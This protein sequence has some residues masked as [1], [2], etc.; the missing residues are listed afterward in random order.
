MWRVEL[1]ILSKPKRTAAATRRARRGSDKVPTFV[2]LIGAQEHLNV[3][4]LIDFQKKDQQSVEN[5]YKRK[6]L[7]KRKVLTYADYVGSNEADIEDMFS[8]D[9]YLKLVNGAFGSSVGLT[10]LA[11]GH[12]RI[13]HRLEEYLESNPLPNNAIF[14]HYRPARYFSD[15]IG[16]LADDL[17]DQ[18]LDRFEQAFVA[19]NAL[20]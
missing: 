7:N 18:E 16:S 6:L 4:V 14:N 17:S 15:N 1:R 9:F 8:P 20:L 11:G 10:D 2:A 12:P 13:L 19:L 5:L 3:A